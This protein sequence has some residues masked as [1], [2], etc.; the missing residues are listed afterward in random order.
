MGLVIRLSS[1]EGSGQSVWE[2][3]TESVEGLLRTLRR[4]GEGRCTAAVRGLG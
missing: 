3:Q 1:R 4:E 2:V